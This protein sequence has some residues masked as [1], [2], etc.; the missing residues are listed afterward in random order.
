MYKNLYTQLISAEFQN[1]QLSSKIRADEEDMENQDRLH[2]L[3][4]RERNLLLN[5]LCDEVNRLRDLLQVSQLTND[6]NN[7]SPSSPH[8]SR[9]TSPLLSSPPMAPVAHAMQHPSH[10]PHS[11]SLSK[12]SSNNNHG[13]PNY[14][15]MTANALN[16]N[17]NTN[18]HRKK[19]KIRNVSGG[20]TVVLLLRLLECLLV[21][22]STFWC[23]FV[24]TSIAID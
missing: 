7:H 22:L 1:G 13:T 21:S 2:R 15:S 9:P 10:R 4:L 3:Q 19:E 18:N 24:G 5:M 6:H 11:S 16:S 23:C 17:Y 12:S 8:L 14:L 20:A